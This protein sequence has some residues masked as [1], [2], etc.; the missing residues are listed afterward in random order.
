MIN[1]YVIYFANKLKKSL[2]QMTKRRINRVTTLVDRQLSAYPLNPLRRVTYYHTLVLII[3]SKALFTLNLIIRLTPNPNSLKLHL[4]YFLLP[5]ISFFW[6]VNK[7]IVLWIYFVNNNFQNFLNRK[8]SYFLN[9]FYDII[10]N[11]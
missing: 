9:F 10:S 7:I 3:F 8:D 1:T 6:I 11:T 4:G 5:R 2:S